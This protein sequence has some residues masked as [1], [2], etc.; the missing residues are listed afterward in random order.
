MEEIKKLKLMLEGK[1]P[2]DPSA[3]LQLQAESS[4]II[5]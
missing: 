1:A 2:M 4:P 3:L 5:Q